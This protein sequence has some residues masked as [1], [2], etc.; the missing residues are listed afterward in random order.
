MVADG[1]RVLILVCLFHVVVV[2]F[3]FLRPGFVIFLL[4]LFVHFFNVLFLL[5]FLVLFVLLFLVLFVIFFLFLFL[6]FLLF[7]IFLLFLFLFL[8]V[9]YFLVFFVVLW[10]SYCYF[11]QTLINA[12]L[13]HPFV[14]WTPSATIPLV[15]TCTAV[16]STMDTLVTTKIAQVRNFGRIMFW[17]ELTMSWETGKV[18][19]WNMTVIHD[20][21]IFIY[22][23]IIIIII[24]PLLPHFFLLLVCLLALGV[25]QNL[26]IFFCRR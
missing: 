5:V 2:V 14:T 4:G 13:H 20:I 8:F 11:F 24:L 10:F 6:F 12:P 17:K 16:L 19:W 1:V 23:F 22:M 3:R 7:G 25:L 15:L 18:I 21:F 26:L 9:L